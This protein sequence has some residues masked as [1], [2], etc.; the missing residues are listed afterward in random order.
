M[1]ESLI[2]IDQFRGLEGETFL[3]DIGE[4]ETLEVMLDEVTDDADLLGQN[5]VKYLPR[6]PFT[7]IF[8]GPREPV[9][10]Q[11]IYILSHS[12]IGQI[13]HLIVPIADLRRDGIY[14]QVIYN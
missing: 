3:V 10:P 12:S 14:Y 5:A 9:L 7:L 2:T 8:R 13:K 4:E 6:T 1:N 11:G